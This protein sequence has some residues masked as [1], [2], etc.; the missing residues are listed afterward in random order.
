[1]TLQALPVPCCSW[2]VV[3][4]R[5]L[6]TL[7][8]CKLAYLYKSQQSSVG[9]YPLE[10]LARSHWSGVQKSVK[11]LQVTQPGQEED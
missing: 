10:K 2:R 11:M 3:P 1:M 6:L 4:S 8:V 7:S 5:A 9:K